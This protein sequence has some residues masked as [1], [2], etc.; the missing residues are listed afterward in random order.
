[1]VLLLRGG[2]EGK[3]GGEGK[4]RGGEEDLL[5]LLPVKILYANNATTIGS[6]LQRLCN[7]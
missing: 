7:D 1:V 3:G 5:D 2:E 4:G 6:N